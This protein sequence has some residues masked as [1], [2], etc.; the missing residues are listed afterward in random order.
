MQPWEEAYLIMLN[1]SFDVF[2]DS[3]C[4]NFIEYFC[5]NVHEQNL[6]EE[7]MFCVSLWFRYESNYGCI[8]KIM[9]A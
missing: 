5:I 6:C 3:I 9:A 7:K 1:D 4:M 8:E 2:F